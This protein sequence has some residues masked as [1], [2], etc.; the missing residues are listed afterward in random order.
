M[1]KGATKM[2]FMYGGKHPHPFF[3]ITPFPAN[4]IHLESQSISRFPINPLQFNIGLNWVSKPQSP[5][6]AKTSLRRFSQL[7][8]MP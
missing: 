3:K 6:L 8:E 5:S 4:S 2:L 1:V 7:P